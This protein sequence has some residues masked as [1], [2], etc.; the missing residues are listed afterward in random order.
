MFKKKHQKKKSENGGPG[1]DLG[2]LLYN[3]GIKG[4]NENYEEKVIIRSLNGS[5][6]GNYGGVQCSSSICSGHSEDR[7]V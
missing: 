6:G 2:S 5:D 4:G 7:C 1:D 3:E